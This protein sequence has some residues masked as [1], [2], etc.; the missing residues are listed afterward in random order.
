MQ[1]AA[2]G[3]ELAA[4]LVLDG[5]AED[6]QRTP[7]LGWPLLAKTL[8]LA[9]DD[10]LTRDA[11]VRATDAALAQDGGPR[12]AALLLCDWWQRRTGPLPAAA[13]QRWHRQ[14]SST[15]IP[16]G[17]RAIGPRLVARAVSQH[18]KPARLPDRP[19]DRRDRTGTRPRRPALHQRRQP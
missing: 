15:D 8:L 3:A 12:A 19:A 2:P 5:L 9:V 16:A 6:L 11:I 17:V 1:F 7:G 14:T 13:R 10:R 18:P 4:D